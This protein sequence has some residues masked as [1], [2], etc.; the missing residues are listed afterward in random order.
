VLSNLGGVA[1]D[2]GDYGPARSL[3]E[4][5]LAIHRELGDQWGIARALYNLATL[6]QHE[7]NYA[8]AQSLYEDSLALAWEL[9]SQETIARSAEGL[10]AVAAAQG[11]AVRALRIGGAADRLRATICAPLSAAENGLFQRMLQPAVRRLGATTAATVW[12]EGQTMLVDEAVVHN[13]EDLA[14]DPI[15][16]VQNSTVGHG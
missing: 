4:E 8:T 15:E 3:S 9:G 16:R 12:A 14:E 13:N 1:G 7:G 11:R 5:G 6:A 10:A 2:Q